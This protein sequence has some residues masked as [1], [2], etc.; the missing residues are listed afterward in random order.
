MSTTTT[1]AATT[2]PESTVVQT[3]TPQ[4]TV[5]PTGTPEVTPEV[6]PGE[7]TP[8]GSGSFTYKSNN[9][10]VVSV[11]SDGV[12]TAKG[13]GTT[14]VTVSYPGLGNQTVP[15]TV[16]TKVKEIKLKYQHHGC[17]DDGPTNVNDLP[18]QKIPM[19]GQ[20]Y[21]RYRL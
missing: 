19:H 14:T 12:I 21:L 3:T 11:S 10:S 1:T 6:T 15:V 4:P 20:S 17:V 18:Y 5:T 13:N 9:T 8:Q 7:T 2:S 16:K